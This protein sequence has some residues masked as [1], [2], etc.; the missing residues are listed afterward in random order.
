MIIGICPGSFDPVTNGH[1]DIIERSAQLVETLY[2]AV[3]RNGQKQAL[4]TVDERVEML[5]LATAHIPNVKVE[6]FEGLLAEYGR[7]KGA[8]IIV[9]GLRAIS[10][11]ESEM[12][13]AS[14]NKRLAPEIETIFLMS[15]AQYS[16][17]SS[18]LLKNVCELG[19]NISGLVPEG[20][21]QRVTER[22]RP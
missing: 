22:L 11:Y 9:K 1:L 4:F 8:K 14:I 15:S 19:G 21:L 17:L 20:I 7:Q 10:D 3:L 13:M 18:S 5:R 6:G 2:V 12:A 16:F